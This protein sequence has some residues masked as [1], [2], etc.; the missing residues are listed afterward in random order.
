LN[1]QRLSSENELAS[2]PFALSNKR[3]SRLLQRIHLAMLRVSSKNDSKDES[4]DERYIGFED[5]DSFEDADGLL[6]ATS[7]RMS[8]AIMECLAPSSKF[9]PSLN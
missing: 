6:T 4:P 2:S 3:R 1:W 9:R 7:I 5:M 8:L